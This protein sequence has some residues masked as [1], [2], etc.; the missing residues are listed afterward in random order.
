M[1]TREEEKEGGGTEGGGNEKDPTCVNRC[2][3]ILNLNNE[4]ENRFYFKAFI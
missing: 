3:H 4:I 1:W 2:E